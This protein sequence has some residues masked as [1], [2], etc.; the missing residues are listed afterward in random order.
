MSAFYGSDRV[1]AKGYATFA[2]D[3]GGIG[4]KWE[5]WFTDGKRTYRTPHGAVPV[6]LVDGWYAAPIDAVRAAAL[7]E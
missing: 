3:N 5:R 7:D 2:S 1:H 4:M 6:T